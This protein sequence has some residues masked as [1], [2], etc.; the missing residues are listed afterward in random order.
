MTENTPSDDREHTSPGTLG[1]GI[2]ITI[3]EKKANSIRLYQKPKTYLCHVELEHLLNAE[4]C[5]T[6]G[7]G[8]RIEVVL[9]IKD[10]NHSTRTLEHTL[11]VGF[12]ISASLHVL[13]HHGRHLGF[14]GGVHAF[15]GHI[16]LAFGAHSVAALL[17]HLIIRIDPVLLAQTLYT[18][19]VFLRLPPLLGCQLS[20]RRRRVITCSVHGCWIWFL[21][22]AVKRCLLLWSAPV[23]GWKFFPIYN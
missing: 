1:S 21:V 19:V 22:C 8:I 5:W 17:W 12:L 7:F 6:D 23:C 16:L 9:I 4:I 11:K 15:I 10:V 18:R 14:R 20:G 2:D 3:T 13:L